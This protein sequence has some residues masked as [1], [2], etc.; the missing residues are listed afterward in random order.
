[1]KIGLVGLV[2]QEWL[3]TLST[4]DESDLDYLDYVTEGS[5]IAKELKQ[6]GAEL[7]IAL[8]HM[9]APNDV[10][11]LSKVGDIDVVLGGHDHSYLVQHVEPHGNLLVKSGTDFRDLTCLW[12]EIDGS[13]QKR[14]A[15]SPLTY[16]IV[17][18]FL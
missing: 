1:M 15:V 5:R 17:C 9:R 14:F 8:T 6:E 16:R 2:E 11:L 18:E 7:V 12:V 10:N 13:G 4:L 3:N